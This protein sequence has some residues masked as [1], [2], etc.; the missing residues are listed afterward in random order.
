[1]KILYYVCIT[2]IYWISQNVRLIHREIYERYIVIWNSHS[3][4]RLDSPWILDW[5]SYGTLHRILATIILRNNS[6]VQVLEKD[7]LENTLGNSI[8]TE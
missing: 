8:L 2:Y 6:N 5:P 3:S 7:F 1:M 4:N